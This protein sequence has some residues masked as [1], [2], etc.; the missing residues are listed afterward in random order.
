[1]FFVRISHY[2][3]FFCLFSF[4]LMLHAFSQLH[5]INFNT[6][7]ILGY[8]PQ[9]KNVASPG[10]SKKKEQSNI[11]A[12]LSKGHCSVSLL[13]C[14]DTLQTMLPHFREMSSSLFY[15]R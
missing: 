12:H 7:L 6:Q 3:T 4:V 14:S 15:M 11:S 8:K 5:S 9:L 13:V 10:R 1:M 2:R